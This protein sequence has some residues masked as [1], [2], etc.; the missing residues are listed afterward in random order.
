MG[1][2]SLYADKAHYQQ[3]HHCHRA[4]LAISQT[5]AS[6]TS[7]EVADK[8][9]QLANNIVSLTKDA[10]QISIAASL[11]A[12]RKDQ[13]TVTRGLQI[14][15]F[16]TYIGLH[17]RW[18]SL[19]TQQVVCGVLTVYI[20]EF[21][22]LNKG[23]GKPGV[24]VETKQSLSFLA[25]S[26]LEVWRSIVA[27]SHYAHVPHRVDT[28]DKKSL[29][30]AQAVVLSAQFL[31][32]QTQKPFYQRLRVCFQ[33]LA[34]VSRHYLFPLC[35]ALNSLPVGSMFHHNGKRLIVVSNMRDHCVCLDIEDRQKP[36]QL[37][38]D[39]VAAKAVKH[40][41]F[42]QWW[43][44]AAP[45]FESKDN[46]YA[47]T[48]LFER[49]FNINTPPSA[50]KTLL[51]KLQD[52]NVELSSIVEVME[53]E[54]LFGEYITQ[55]ASQDNRLKL[56]V[57]SIKQGVMTYGL[58]RIGDM[59]TQQALYKRLTQHYFP[60]LDTCSRLT[61]LTTSIASYI[62][63]ETGI[64]TPQHAGL[65]A[66]VALSPLFTVP[67]LKIL[68]RFHHTETHYYS[69]NSLIS[70]TGNN[71]LAD[72]ASQLVEKW[73][74]PREFLT[75][76]SLQGKMPN[77]VPIRYRKTYCLLSLSVLLARKWQFGIYSTCNDSETFYIQGREI[78]GL[79]NQSI[80]ALRAQTSHLVYCTFPR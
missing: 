16:T 50:L 25:S 41:D 80:E 70:V 11:N 61:L 52:P 74:L 69:I 6:V 75:L 20:N 49:T 33:Y 2:S 10:P 38:Y 28:V 72:F 18:N 9:K 77:T 4:L 35:H 42:E 22:S 15:V 5:S 40:V 45:S 14:A 31:V 78:L 8:V 56:P 3:F 7:D 39:K 36:I 66:T 48:K 44:L 67:A 76:L 59:L 55:S 21:A 68:L 34:P 32:T 60:L 53:N 30:M 27:L 24:S 58:E 26:H 19:Y 54:P 71:T 1:A 29:S 51:A 17:N 79:T 46:D 62:A 65:L 63:L 43:Q 23:L 73:Q 57:S 37:E 47:V 64:M 12:W 13:K